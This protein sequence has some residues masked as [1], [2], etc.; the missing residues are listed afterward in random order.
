MEENQNPYQPQ[1]NEYQ[2]IQQNSAQ[3]PQQYPANNQG[4]IYQEYQQPVYAVKK[5]I[6]PLVI[7]LPIALLI[8]A[9]AVALVIILFGKTS[10]KDAE[11]K[12]FSELYSGLASVDE[13]ENQSGTDININFKLANPQIT[14]IIGF[15]DISFDFQSVEQGDNIYNLFNIAAGDFQLN[16]ENWIGSDGKLVLSFPDIT[17]VYITGDIENGQFEGY[18]D[19][20]KKYLNAFGRIVELTSEDY[21]EMIGEPEVVKNQKLYIQGTEYTADKAVISLTYG[22]TAQLAKTFVQNLTNDE[23]VMEIICGLYGFDSDEEAKEALDIYDFI[24]DMNYIIDIANNDMEA[25]RMTVWIKGRDIVGRDI[26]YINCDENVGELFRLYDMPVDEGK[27][28]YLAEGSIFGAAGGGSASADDAEEESYI[29]INDTAK[30]VIH[31]GTLTYSSYDM[32]VTAEYSDFAVSDNMFQGK[33]S[34]DI[35]GYEV[36]LDL[37]QNG[38]SKTVKLSVPNICSVDITS[39]PSDLEYKDIPQIKEGEY[40]DFNDLSNGTDSEAMEKFQQELEDFISELT[41]YDDSYYDDPYDYYD[42]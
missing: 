37:S 9:A 31:S 29:L 34:A 18:A 13:N 21:F 6:N 3:A 38:E 24:E 42:F 36:T 30:G 27:I 1:Q 33:A 5:K 41:G 26:V 19:E 20:Y 16:A 7:I 25:F 23:E 8:I 14:D 10:Y 40:I 35:E 12:Y 4:Y 39:S 11:I 2:N 15:S 17:S 32:E 28:I 22:Q